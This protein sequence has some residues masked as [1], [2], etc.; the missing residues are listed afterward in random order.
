MYQ[1]RHSKR[2]KRLCLKVIP[3][4]V[5]L[6]VPPHVS[7]DEAHAFARE[8]DD[9]LQKQLKHLARCQKQPT[10][11]WP[12]QTCELLSIE[13]NW[14]VVCEYREP[15]HY[16]SLTFEQHKQEFCLGK[17]ND[18]LRSVLMQW[19]KSKATDHFKPWL[20]QLAQQ[21][22]F[23]LGKI[24]FRNQKGRWGSCNHNKDIS[25]NIKL[26]FL[27]PTVAE[28][29][30]IHELCHT[31]HANHSQRFWQLVGSIMPSYKQ[32]EAALRRWQYKTPGWL[33]DV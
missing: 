19:L 4:G 6:V 18:G 8:H 21:H 24:S 25:L 9:W 17:T 3:E 33:D 28:Y 27:P 13:Q 1:I 14:Q 32:S 26:L 31:V 23:G 7:L 30:M 15:S 16:L 12:P 22:Q 20:Q 2:A 10:H 29:V 11:Q 5:E